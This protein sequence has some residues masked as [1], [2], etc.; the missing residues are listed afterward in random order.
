MIGRVSGKERVVDTAALAFEA[1]GVRTAVEASSPELLE[2][3]HA[4]LPPG[5]VRCDGEEVARTFSIRVQ[6]LGT[7]AIAVEGIVMSQGLDLELA[8]GVLDSQLRTSIAIDAPEVVFIHAGV[9]AHGDGVIVLPGR[10][11]S[12]KTTLVAALVEAGATY[13][14]DEFAVIDR[15][16]LVHP[17]AKPLSLRGTDY[18][19]KEHSVESLGG[20]AGRDPL[21]IRAVVVT[22]YRAGAEWRPKRLSHGEGAMALLANAV[23]AR[24]HP[25]EVMGVLPRALEAAVVIESERGEAASVVPSLLA[26]VEKLAA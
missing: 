13:Y 26:D 12:G 21:P 8:L 25:R 15:S 5:S 7:Y 14:S 20:V 23:A 3:V 16:G 19:Q 24:D 18:R 11:F 9:V 2:R 6:E 22:S 10:S 1:F 17:Y 4:V